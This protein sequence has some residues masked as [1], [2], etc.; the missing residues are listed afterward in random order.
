[1]SLTGD[2]VAL[3]QYQHHEILRIGQAEPLQQRL[4]EA[5]EGMRGG[6]DRK[7]ELVAE[8]QGQRRLAALSSSSQNFLV[9]P[10][11]RM[12]HI[13]AGAARIINCGQLNVTPYFYIVHN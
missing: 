1:M 9:R 10:V 11:F 8:H 5:V 3:P 13:W 12:S 4:V 7:A 2:A 6:V